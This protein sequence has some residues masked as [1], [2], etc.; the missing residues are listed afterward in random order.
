MQFFLD[1]EVTFGEVFL[2][3]GTFGFVVGIGVIFAPMT[4]FEDVV[5]KTVVCTGII[6]LFEEFLLP[7]PVMAGIVP[8]QFPGAQPLPARTLK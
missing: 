3:T 4:F 6:T 1:D 8:L 5:P 7:L 2:T